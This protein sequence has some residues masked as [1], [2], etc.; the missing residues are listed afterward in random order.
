MQGGKRR[1]ERHRLHPSASP[2]AYRL[3][4][5]ERCGYSFRHSYKVVI[6]GAYF[7]ALCRLSD[8]LHITCLAQSRHSIHVHCFCFYGTRLRR[9]GGG[10]HAAL[11]LVPPRVR[12]AVHPHNCSWR[13]NPTTWSTF[14]SLHLSAQAPALSAC[15]SSAEETRPQ[16]CR[17]LPS[18]AP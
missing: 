7:R 15:A 4:D 13:P 12:C 1:L 8:I 3:H 17:P 6:T 9:S 2:A 11:C 18:Q 14:R 16:P 5:T 10:K